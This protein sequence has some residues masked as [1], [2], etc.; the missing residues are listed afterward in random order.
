[1]ARQL[2]LSLS[3]PRGIPLSNIPAANSIGANSAFNPYP[4]AASVEASET[5]LREWIN[6]KGLSFPE[7][8]LENGAGLS[9]IESISPL[10]LS[11]LLQ[12]IQL[13]PYAAEIE[14]SLPIVGVDGT[15]KR[16]LDNNAVTAHAHLKTGSLEGVKSI[17]GYVQSRSGKQWILVFFINHARASAGQAAQDEMIEWMEQTL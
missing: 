4:H 16:R 5:A 2:F 10:N 15:L 13:S 14:A 17:A 1:M 11:L 7:L 8:V 3:M 6:K 12:D 9:R